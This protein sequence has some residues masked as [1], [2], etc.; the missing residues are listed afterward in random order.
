M[1]SRGRANGSKLME[2]RGRERRKDLV[3]YEV[4]E[5]R[6]LAMVDTVDSWYLER[7][8]R[9]QRRHGPRGGKGL[10]KGRGAKAQSRG[11]LRPRPAH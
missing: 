10:E 11:G 5:E 6:V 1:E 9:A 7:V 2:S 3:V 4:L 8:G